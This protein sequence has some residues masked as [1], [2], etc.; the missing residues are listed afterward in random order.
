MFFSLETIAVKPDARAAA[1]ERHACE[2]AAL[3]SDGDPLIVMQ[4]LKRPRHVHHPKA[5][6]ASSEDRFLAPKEL[7]DHTEMQ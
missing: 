6:Q 3:S 5:L 4:G 2:L 7:V 1:R